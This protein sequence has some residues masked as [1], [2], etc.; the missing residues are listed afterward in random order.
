MKSRF[1]IVFGIGAAL[2]AYAVLPAGCPPVTTPPT[3][4]NTGL[5]G[6][7]IGSETCGACHASIHTNWAGTLHA[8][9]LE[10]LEAIGQGSNAEC[11]PCHTVGFGQEGGFVDRQT[12]N[13]LAGVGCEDC[14]GAAKDHVQNVGD[15]S[16][17]PNVTIAASLC[18]TCHTDTHHP[19][20]DQWKESGHAEVTEDP[21]EEFS[22]GARL[23]TC[24]VCHSGD[25]RFESVIRGQ[26]V[27]DNALN[28]VAPKD[29]NAVTCAIC[30]D[31]HKQTGNAAAPVT[32][33]DYQL[34][35]SEVKSPAPKHTVADITNVE[36]YNLC[37]QC[38]H[39]RG[40]VWTE[41]SRPT[42]HSNQSNVYIGEMP[43]P[44]GESLLVLSRVSVHSFA[45]AQCATCHMY[46]QPFQSEEN[47][48]ISGHLFSVN[49][50]ACAASGCHP[51]VAAAKAAKVTLQAEIE[52]LMDDI[53][54]RLGAA[55]T[56]EYVSEG[57]P[58]DQTTVSDD[59]KKIRFLYHFV[60][61]DGSRGVHNPA[62]VRS[63]LEEAQA[64]LTANGM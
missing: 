46:R 7:Y 56:W 14:H 33:Q 63:I 8:T 23:N 57:G 30:H 64:L 50:K 5:T 34:R 42:H 28:G 29:M 10:A 36:R 15:P 43:V 47:P 39:D 3:T 41:T 58:A 16:F 4:G 49:T 54:S 11:L 24:G 35:Y 37:G 12:T 25:F 26:T 27:A 32:G 21:A 18:G 52:G 13:L 31:P 19:N 22:A 2:L 53:T 59:V 20:F 60:L 55:S 38:H 45:P 51:S 44:D 1:L 6:K 62:Y 17:Y 9:A 61:S 40:R 48:T